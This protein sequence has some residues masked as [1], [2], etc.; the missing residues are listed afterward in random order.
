MT[1]V[2]ATLEVAIARQ[3]EHQVDGAASG[4]GRGDE[5]RSLAA[6]VLGHATALLATGVHHGV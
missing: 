6:Q 4:N 1:I 5:G 2:E 3:G